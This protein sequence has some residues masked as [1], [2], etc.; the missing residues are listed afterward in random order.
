MKSLALA[1]LLLFAPNAFAQ[2]TLKGVVRN[3]HGGALSGTTV[4]VFLKD[5]RREEQV[6]GNDGRYSFSIPA[7]ATIGLVE[8]DN[9]QW[10]PKYVEELSGQ[11]PDNQVINK[12]LSDRNGP[13]QF[14]VVVDQLL[15][16][17]HFYITGVTKGQSR[18]ALRRRFGARIRNIPDP[19][20]TDQGE[21]QVSAIAKWTPAQRAVI[22]DL[23]GDVLDLYGIEDNAAEARDQ[24]TSLAEQALQLP[25]EAPAAPSFDD[26]APAAPAPAPAENESEPP[27]SF[28]LR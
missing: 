24:T 9:P 20:R 28:R 15:V 19:A 16:Y 1:L 17:E 27:A 10:H 3:P 7:G 21:K 23:V 18:A 5:G 12:V 22:S 13:Q 26:S 4:R 25:Q 8:Y 14:D 6:T 2:V 11:P